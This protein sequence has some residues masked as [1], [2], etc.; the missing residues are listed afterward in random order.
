[1]SNISV[2]LENILKAVYGK[3][4]RQSIHDSIAQCYSD[5]DAAIT[6]ADSYVA[7]VQQKITECEAAASD[8][9]CYKHSECFCI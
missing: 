5:V 9:R 2:L 4:V 8:A 3:D 6:L 7:T 1:M